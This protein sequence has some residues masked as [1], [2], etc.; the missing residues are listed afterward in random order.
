MSD[1]EEFMAGTDPTTPRPNFRISPKKLSSTMFRLEWPSAPGQQFQVQGSTN[2]VSWSPS[3]GWIVAT[4]SVTT[5]D[6]S[7]PVYG[8]RAFFRVQLYNTNA[9]STLAP[10]LKLS[11]RATTNGQILLN[12]NS[13]PG[14]AYQV[15][16]STNGT[17]WMSISGWIPAATSSMNYVVPSFTPPTPYLF[18]LQ[19]EP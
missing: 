5:A 18:R 19:V 1:F 11:A 7:I 12:W 17:V 15:Q 8:P 2:L 14:R 10:N 4:G 6:I 16:G 13:S 3:G 9:V